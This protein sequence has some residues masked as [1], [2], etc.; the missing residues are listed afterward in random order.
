MSDAADLDHD[1]LNSLWALVDYHANAHPLTQAMM[2]LDRRTSYGELYAAVLAVSDRLTADGIG[3]GARVGYVGKNC[4]HYFVMLF[5]LSRIGAVMV[6]INWRLAPEEMAYIV[7]DSTMVRLFTD[8]EYLSAATSLTHDAGLPPA[9]HISTLTSVSPDRPSGTDMAIAP[10]PDDVVF[11]VYTSGTTGRPKGALLTNANLLGLRAPGYRAGLKWFPNRYSSTAIVLPIA[12]IA[13]TAY[14][15]FGFYAGG[16]V[17]ILREFDPGEVLRLIEQ[18]SITHLL[19]APSALQMVAEHPAVATTNLSCLAIITY[20]AAPMPAALLHRALAL[21]GCG[22][23]QMYG[24]TEAAGGVVALQPEDH[25]AAI[26]DRLR[27]AGRAMPSVEVDIVD[28]GWKSLPTGDIGE[29][30]VRSP[31]VMPGYWRRPDATEEILRPDGW[32]RTGDIGRMDADGYVYV[33]D[34]AKDMIISGGEN[35]YPAEVENAIFGHPA[36]ADVAVVSAPSDKWGETVVAVIVPCGDHAPSLAELYGWL[37]GRLARF[38]FPK[39]IDLVEELPRN[40]G[41]KV[42]RRLLRDRYWQQDT[43]EAQ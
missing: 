36:I 9:R 31:S 17:A 4:D 7:A 10:Q 12:H 19:L 39:R 21:F 25:L 35:I 6:P 22:F 38:K 14:A 29:I 1:R 42:I 30:V 8:D 26:G 15:L 40:A 2:F 16:T 37:D 32:M 28:E 33:L 24:M 5:A 41:N 13:G 27:S 3:R 18:E 43:N 34:R 23:V 11:Q 20:G